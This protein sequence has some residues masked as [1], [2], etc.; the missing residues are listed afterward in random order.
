MK[1]WWNRIPWV[2]RLWIRAHGFA[3][4]LYASFFGSTGWYFLQKERFKDVRHWPSV[5]AED[6]SSRR[7]TLK[8]P[9]TE[10]AQ[11]SGGA[12]FIDIPSV[13]YTYVVDGVAHV[14][15]RGRPD[16]NLLPRPDIGTDG[17][18]RWR[19]FYHP[20]HPGWA[21]LQPGPYQI[22]AGLLT[23][24]CISGAFVAVHLTFTLALRYRP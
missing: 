21:V 5:W 11:G 18:E 16:D 20:D 14:G 2:W 1:A 6:V 24:I 22:T 15:S 9:R 7:D 8:Q 19:V 4:L 12:L 13:K 10:T 3:V 23:V 17:V